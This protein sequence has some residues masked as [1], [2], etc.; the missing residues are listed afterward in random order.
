MFSFIGIPYLHRFGYWA[1]SVAAYFL[2][3]YYLRRLPGDLS[4]GH[5]HLHYLKCTH[6]HSMPH[7][8]HCWEPHNTGYSLGQILSCMNCYRFM[9]DLIDKY[10]IMRPSMIA[11]S[12]KV[13]IP[14]V[15]LGVSNPELINYLHSINSL[16]NW[17]STN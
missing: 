12:V 16:N 2:Y 15:L 3:R 8:L 6:H 7:H 14:F 5:F 11:I 9:L 4:V 1:N 13:S 17:H 10:F